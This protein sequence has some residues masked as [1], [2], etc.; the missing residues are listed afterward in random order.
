V[1]LVEE[2]EQRLESALAE[3]VVTARRRMKRGTAPLAITTWV[4]SEV[5]EAMLV[6]AQAASNW[7]MALFELRN[8]TKRGTTPHSITRSIGGFFSLESSLRNLVVASS[9]V[10]WSFE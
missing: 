9:W 1:V 8:S 3:N 10:S 2:L 7:S 5:P 4:C 6:R